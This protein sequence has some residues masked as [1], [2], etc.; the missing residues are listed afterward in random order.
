MKTTYLLPARLKKFGWLILIPSLLLG[1]PAA[2]FEWS[3]AF[4]DLNVL[5]LFPDNQNPFVSA[6]ENSRFIGLTENN[7]LNELLG[8]ATIIGALIVAFAKEP[9]EDEYISKIRLEC[10]VWAT[11]WN[12]GILVVAF[13]LVYDIQFYWVML[14][15]M[16]TIPLLFTLRFNWLVWKLR[17]AISDEE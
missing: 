13:L 11:Y 8:I 1:I 2:I 16:F 7:I 10:L 15:N 4:L 12:F 5:S 17:K 3:P 14:F 6:Q 9:D